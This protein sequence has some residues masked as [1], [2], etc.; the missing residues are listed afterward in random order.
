M[1]A[2]S[3]TAVAAS[4]R[5]QPLPAGNRN[6]TFQKNRP[7]GL[8]APRPRVASPHGSAPVI[9]RPAPLK[10]HGFRAAQAT[11]DQIR[12]RRPYAW[13]HS[14]RR[15]A[16]G[17]AQLLAAA[18]LHSADG[19]QSRRRLHSARLW[20]R[21]GC[22]SIENGARMMPCGSNAARTQKREPLMAIRAVHTRHAA[23]RS[24]PAIA[25]YAW[26][27]CIRPPPG[28]GCRQSCSL[29]SRSRAPPSRG[30]TL[31]R[32]DLSR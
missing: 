4:I 28:G 5:R 6:R 14:P 29:R 18:Q 30:L 3:H 12:T 7:W 10:W 26:R 19:R 23:P 16:N 31:D 24:P 32:S 21:R 25:C 8:R 20:H 2:P 15:T 22:R 17:A 9:R 27:C 13:P 1:P 11:R